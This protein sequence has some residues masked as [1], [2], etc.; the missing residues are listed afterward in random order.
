MLPLEL[1]LMVMVDQVTSDFLVC[2][3]L[4]YFG[5]SAIDWCL[6]HISAMWEVMQ[7]PTLAEATLQILK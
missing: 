5:L 2:Y 1:V 7:L 6:G 4:V 3:T